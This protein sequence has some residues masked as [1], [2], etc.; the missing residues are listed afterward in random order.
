MAAAAAM[1]C[2]SCPFPA[3]GYSGGFTG[4][5]TVEV[6][7]GAS[8]TFTNGG[9]IASG[10]TFENFGTATLNSGSTLDRCGPAL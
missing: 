7:S 6:D 10:D 9:S 3:L 4:F 2:W 1:M 8:W 5:S